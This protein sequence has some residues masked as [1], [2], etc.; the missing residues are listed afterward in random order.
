MPRRKYKPLPGYEA[1]ISDI[2]DV[3][4]KHHSTVYITRRVCEHLRAEVETILD[5]HV[6]QKAEDRK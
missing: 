3:F 5:G 6:F 1:V 2:L 4:E